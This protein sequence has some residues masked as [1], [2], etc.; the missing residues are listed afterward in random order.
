MAEHLH[1]YV[2][3]HRQKEKEMDS[4]RAV[5]ATAATRKKTRV[6][7]RAQTPIQTYKRDQSKNIVSTNG[8]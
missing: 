8:R 7:V 4:D 3:Q 1:E 6:W 2:K 5:A